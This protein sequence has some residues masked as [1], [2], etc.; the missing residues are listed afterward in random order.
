MFDSSLVDTLWGTF[1]GSLSVLITT[2]AGY[3]AARYEFLD[4]PTVKRVSNISSLL[5]LPCLIVVQMGPYLTAQELGTVWIMPVWG[6]LS[7]VIAHLLGWL[8]KATLRLEWWTVVASGRANANALP[9]LLLQSL[10]NSGVLSTLR[11]PGES[12][13]ETLDRAKSIVLLNSVIQQV[14]TFS[15]GSSLLRR[16][17]QNAKIE[18][19]DP[20][21]DR[22]NP[23]SRAARFPA[24]QDTE[25]VGLLR[26]YDHDESED[27][28]F[29]IPFNQLDNTPDLDVWSRLPVSPRVRRV[30]YK[31]RKLVKKG[32]SWLNPP[33][34]GACVALFLGMIPALHHAF[35]SKDGFF[36]DS[37]TQA[38]K[39]LGGLFVSL[40]MF[41]LGADLAL[42][43][44]TKPKIRGTISVL[45]IRYLLM[46]LISMAFVYFTAGKGWYTDDPLVWF[47]L[48]LV[49]SGPSA[50]VLI[51]L[52]ELMNIDQG[53]IA[54]FL[55]L[56]YLLSPFISVVCTMA[57]KVVEVVEER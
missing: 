50:M 20:E 28:D 36:Y 33:V 22:L 4:R 40:Q 51:N 57:L 52:A 53:P 18:N 3:L 27:D 16:D 41:I 11:K 55:A 42:V 29:R 30:F 37:L 45:S 54:G 48:I 26:D 31:S 24:I 6:L 9:L 15:L 5:F 13:T 8:G 2:L 35:L 17:L 12:M 46:P 1:Q 38:V 7:S 23:G 56:S 49:P 32:F 47:L 19:C 39:N 43:P 44:S 21:G 34:A 25:H 14:I 10:E